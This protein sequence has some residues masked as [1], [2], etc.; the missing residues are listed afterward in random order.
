ML[1]PAANPQQIAFFAEHGFV[2]V[3]QALPDAELDTLEAHCDT[4]L[5]HK[6]TLANDWAWSADEK[7]E[8]R[9]FRIVQS[10]RPRS[11][12]TSRR[13]PTATGWS[14]SARD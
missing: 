4:L 5:A 1:Y 2:V 6:Q 13:S 9:S 14:G 8:E 12:R 10:S 7:R 3:R 11:G